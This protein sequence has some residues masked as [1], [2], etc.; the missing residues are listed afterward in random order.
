MIY[1]AIIGDMVG[2]RFEFDMGGKTKK[3]ELFTKD[4]CYTDDTV[5]TI[6]LAQAFDFAKHV[7]GGVDADEDKMKRAFT[8]MMQ[9][10]GRRY[11]NAGYGQSFYKWVMGRTE[12]YG[13][14]GNG[15]AM[16]V[17]SVGWMYDSLERTREVARWSAEISHNHPEGIKGAECTA[18]VIFLA[19][20]GM[21]KDEIMWYV[22]QEFGYNMAYSVDEWRRLHKHVETC[23]DSLPKALAAFN[24][25]E[26][27]EDVIR[28]AVS[29]GGDT[30]TIAAIAGAMAEAYYEVPDDIRDQCLARLPKDMRDTVRS[31]EA[32]LTN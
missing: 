28:N 26:D 9:V 11:P 4:S 5:M 31:L 1:G 17:S 19:R 21:D 7:L 10:W 29:L 30:D 14:F 22:M 15:S 20:S 27:F 18:T 3:F 2:S 8:S 32:G 23:M 16:R 6:A 13:S 12:P 24:E 25:G